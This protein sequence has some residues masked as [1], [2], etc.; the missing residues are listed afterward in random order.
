MGS[1]FFPPPPP[2]IGG[3]QPYADRRNVPPSIAAV[4][5]DNPPPS[6]PGKSEITRTILA[7]WQPDP[8]TYNFAGNL[9][10]FQA[11]QLPPTRAE[12]PPSMAIRRAIDDQIVQMWQPPPPQPHMGRGQPLEPRKLPPSFMAVRVDNPPP[13]QQGRTDWQ[14]YMS[15]APL[16][17]LPTLTPHSVAP[18]LPPVRTYIIVIT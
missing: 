9:Q 13:R 5:V 17:P 4:R 12:F 2:M 8:W 16:P 15:Y 10:P 6:H 7:M 14:I 11:R 1:F 18:L 3:T